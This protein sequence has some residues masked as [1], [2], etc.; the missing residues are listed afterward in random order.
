MALVALVL[1]ARAAEVDPLLPNATQGI[2]TVN[3]RQI[4]D[5]ALVKKIGLD[6]LRALLSASPAQKL[7][8]E[9]DFDPFKD[10]ASITYAATGGSDTDKGLLIVHGKFDVEKCHAKAEDVAKALDVPLKIHK[11]GDYRVYEASAPNK[12]D[13]P[14]F[15]ALV[16]KSTV[17]FAPN[18]DLVLEALD[19]AAGKKQAAVKPEVRALIEKTRAGQSFW[20]AG[21]MTNELAALPIPIDAQT[22]EVLEKVKTLMGGFTL[23]DDVK[24]EFA[25]GA[26]NA[27]AAKDIADLV[28]K[29]V[30]KGKEVAGV[31]GNKKEAGPVIELLD[32]VKV[33]QQ[34]S[35]VT[36]KG[37]LS[38]QTLDKV[39]ERGS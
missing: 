32:S 26:P 37:Q 22:K 24:I 10:L 19:K 27:D 23:A 8:D 29:G 15:V 21:V 4:L 31:L 33:S 39:L 17:V 25:L 38:K 16:D 20:L 6:Q 11:L 36:I 9:V 14:M 28:Q 3:V 30:A 2:S 5:S 12:K 7:L 13:Q 34:G 1:P 18:K 35:D